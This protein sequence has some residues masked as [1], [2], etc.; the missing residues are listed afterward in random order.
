MAHYLGITL[1]KQGSNS[2][3]L[4]DHEDSNPSFSIFTGGNRWKF[5]GCDRGGGAIDFVKEYLDVSFLDAKKWLGD[6]SGLTVGRPLQRSRQHSKKMDGAL[7]SVHA[8]PSY[9]EP[10]IMTTDTRQAVART[11]S[12]MIESVDP[13]PIKVRVFHQYRSFPPVT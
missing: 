12:D 10:E 1:P 6:A 2:C 9:P 8:K 4:P 11:G 7:S 13:P 3:P 5:Y